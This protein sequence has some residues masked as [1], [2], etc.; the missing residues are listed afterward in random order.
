MLYC[1]LALKHKCIK[2]II[3]Y[4]VHF[5]IPVATPRT[6]ID[7]V[8]ECPSLAVSESDKYIFC[9]NNDSWLLAYLITG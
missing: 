4:A 1:Y 5:V 8:L 7:Q 9:Y 3:L 2:S 6:S